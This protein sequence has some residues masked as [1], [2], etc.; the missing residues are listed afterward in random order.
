MALRA[1]W[2]NLRS[3]VVAALSPRDRRRLRRR[4]LLRCESLEGREVPDANFMGV[5][6]SGVEDWSTD[7]MFA[8][9]M[10]SA[11]RPSDFGSHLGQP[12]ID[13]NGWPATDCSIVAWHGIGNMNGTYKLSFSGQADISTYWGAANIVNKA[14]NAATNTTTADLIYFP[15]DGSGLLLNFRNSRRT[16]ASP[17]NTGVTNIRLMR[18][19]FPGSTSSYSPSDTFTQPLK[20]LVNKFSV[21][22]MMDNTGSNGYQDVNGNW[23]NRRQANYASQAAVGPAKG[24]AWEYAIQFWN[25]TDK[26]AWVNVPFTADDNYITQLATLLKNNLEPGRKI[27][28]EYSNELWN[29]WGPFPGVA[30]RDAAVAEV[31][32]NPN[33]PLN[34]DG[35]YPSRD[36]DGWQL[37]R[38][39]IALRSAQTSNIFRQVFGDSEMMSRVRPVLMSQLGWT[40]GWLGTELDYV[41]DYLDN[42]RYQGTPHS[43]SYYFYGAGGSAY[44]DPDWSI[45]NGI[46]VD[47]I[48][49]TMPL[50]FVRDLRA[51][52]DLVAAFGLKRIAYEGGPS[53]DN[54]VN[55]TGV[56]TSTLEAAW[57]DP[58]MRTE[59]VD[60]HHTWSANGGD[61]FMY[62]ASTGGVQWGLTHDVFSTDT[63][64][65]RAINDLNSTPAA[66]VTYG[67]PAPVDLIRDDFNV[68]YG[69]GSIASMQADSLATGWQ[70]A[71]FRVDNAAGYSVRA[72]ATSSNGGRVEV[73]VDGRSVG[74]IDVPASGDTVTI[75]VGTL[76]PGSHGILLRARAGSFG[77][78]R[79]SVVA[80]SVS[81]PAAPDS[82]TATAISS[83]QIN[84]AWADRSNDETGFTID[85][86]T[87]ASFTA[88]LASFNVGPNVSTYSDT[89]LAA[90]TTY[91]YRV[92]AFNAAGQSAYSNIASAT[93]QDQ[94]PT[95]PDNLT[96]T[97][98]SSSQINL[99]W[100]DRSSN[101]T[102]FGIDRA[103]NAAF[104]NGLA[105]FNVNAN[106]TTYADTGLAPATTYY[107]RVR[108]FNASGASGYS[109]TASA[110]TPSQ[111]PAAPDN[112]N[113][114]ALSSSQVNLAW[115]DRS[116][117]ETGFT[118]DRATN[119]SFTSGLA[120][121]NVGTNVTTYADTGL[122][123]ATTYYYRVRAF[124]AA[125]Q[126]GNSNTASA[127]TFP[128]SSPGDTFG[129][130]GTYFDN[131]NFTGLMLTRTDPMVNFEWGGGSPWPQFGADTFSVRWIGQVQ[132]LESG[133]YFFR[134][135]TDDGVRL[136][137]NGNLVINNWTDHPGTDNT[138]QG[139]TLTA[140]ARYDLRLE[141][142]E[143]GGGAVMRLGWQRPG[144]ST[145][146]IIP[147]LQLHP[148]PG[149]CA[150]FADNFD[151]GL[152]QWSVQSGQWSAMSS[153]AGRGWVYATTGT[154]MNRLSLAG[155]PNWQNYSVA[156]W[157]NLANLDGGA[158]IV[159][160]VVDSTHYYQ[161]EIRRDAT[162]N[163]GWFLWKRDG[164]TWVQLAAGSLAYTAGS[165]IRLRLSM[166]GSSLKA[167]ASTDGINYTVL[168]STLDGSYFA[169]RF[170]LR[171]SQ[172]AAY[173][174]DLLVQGT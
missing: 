59:V 27:Y 108:A 15:G 132:A 119:A 139:I 120:S 102:G 83:S 96:A 94:L 146:D 142:Y 58:R 97:A 169:G 36:P 57:N 39:R 75:P 72:T 85:R 30:N 160:R 13:S 154:G 164:N 157:V 40:G 18:P 6:L 56:P 25:E 50:D 4:P 3:A 52:I 140:G 152:S 23:G 95:A 84:L 161:L 171:A 87:N 16:P 66:P 76:Q 128:Q 141:Y 137:I 145:F 73:F 110:T 159:G 49:T 163:P 166:T 125:G 126:S 112:L 32:A 136:W 48:F 1:L 7:R 156:A 165:W 46:T 153:F 67:K 28:L 109:N 80:G 31:Q 138:S 100:A 21:V 121:F 2:S 82:L 90:A 34:F 12:P 42:P 174:N 106:V 71:M 69:Q 20:D 17:L 9:A 92:R 51:D 35:M 172:S 107:Y 168:G 144:Q 37:A 47:Q 68:T 11:R 118:I 167:E 116:S 5:N 63:Q 127:T 77:L 55:N 26:D 162:G 151:T 89:G 38:R 149:G 115:N 74:I 88:G 22:R 33:S 150:L 114:T 93:T 70:A 158:G 53:L 29:T 91:Y 148:A 122:T 133:T 44:E 111:A 103:T 101:E 61:L 62:F 43:A 117:D 99:A 170:G 86:A 134:T 130:A 8:D 19:L 79:V 81:P 124:N 155:N 98:A 60:N 131:Q 135:H 105:S 41:E 104:T 123:P 78:S 54:V 65:F 143:A 14:Y 173:F 24:M 10:K 147:E 129:L 113:A 64:K 45:G